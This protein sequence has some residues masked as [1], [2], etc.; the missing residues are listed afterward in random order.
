MCA[1][2]KQYPCNSRCPNAPEPEPVLT[3]IRCEEG[4]FAG[5]K[6]FESDEGPICEECIH[7]MNGIEVLELIGEEMIEAKG[8]E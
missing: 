6:Y 7:D 2:C 8:D 4:I 1:L 5:S 3:C